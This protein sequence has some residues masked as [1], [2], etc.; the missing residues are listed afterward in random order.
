VACAIEMQNALA[1]FNL[2]QRTQRLPELAMGIGI[3]T[4][5]VIVGNIGSLKRSKYGAV[6][7]AINTTYRIESHTVGGQILISPSTYAGVRSLVHVRGTLQAQFKGLDHPVTLY[8]ISG[9]DAPY[10][11]SLPVR[12]V[13]TLLP[14][15]PPLPLACF[16]IAG[17]IVSDTAIAGCLTHLSGSAAAGNLQGQVAAYSNVKLILTPADGP[18]LADVYAKILTCDP[19]EPGTS[20]IQ[21][22]F[23]A[24]PATAQAFLERCTSPSTT[25]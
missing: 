15:S 20:H 3:N 13:A 9:I 4:G 16:P 14:L 24:L 25:A 5:E 11:L 23:T 2:E 22:E 7:N 10:H 6:G 12:P 8:D 1:A 18:P 19:S 21:L 17:K